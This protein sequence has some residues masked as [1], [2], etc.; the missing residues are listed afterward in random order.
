MSKAK[1]ISRFSGLF[2]AKEKSRFSGLFQGNVAIKEEVREPIEFD[3]PDLSQHFGETSIGE[4]ERQAKLQERPIVEDLIMKSITA[5]VTSFV[6]GI[7]QAVQGATE[8]GKA[9]GKGLVT[10]PSGIQVPSTIPNIKPREPSREIDT[11]DLFV[12]AGKMVAGTIGATFMA[13]PIVAKMTMATPVLGEIGDKVAG[14]T[15]RKIAEL[16]TPYLFSLPLGV[17]SSGAS[18]IVEAIKTTDAFKGL[19]AEAQAVTEEVIHN[20]ALFAI[21]PGLAKI[22][23][24]TT[25]PY[26]RPETR[27]ERL[28][29]EKPPKP[30][31][32]ITTKKPDLKKEF[33]DKVESKEVTKPVEGVTQ[34]KTAVELLAKKEPV[35]AEEF[36]KPIEVPAVKGLTQE[37]FDIKKDFPKATPEELF[38]KGFSIDEVIEKLDIKAA[39]MQSVIV[40]KFNQ[41]Q[42]T[43]EAKPKEVVK[44]PTPE[45]VITDVA[46][47]Q[48]IKNSIAEGEMI[49]K[50]SKSVTGRK[51][52]KDE[53]F[54]VQRSVDNAKKKIGIEPTIEKVKPLEATPKEV[55]TDTKVVP[56]P[57]AIKEAQ[58][59]LGDKFTSEFDKFTET[60]KPVE[61]KDPIF[62]EGRILE[63]FARKTVAAD[64]LGIGIEGDLIGEANK[65][66][67]KETPKDI[68]TKELE[69]ISKI[70]RELK[71]EALRGKF[72]VPERLREHDKDLINYKEALKQKFPNDA[73]ITDAEKGHIYAIEAAK[74]KGL[75]FRQPKHEF[76]QNDPKADEF[77][78][79]NTKGLTKPTT[80]KK[81][82]VKPEAKEGKQYPIAPIG[83]WYGEAN[84]KKAGGE[85]VEMTPD[86]FLA[87]AKPLEIDETARENID[88]LK[89][90]MKSGKTLDPLTLY[91]LDKTNVR[92]SD[93]RHRAIAAKELG[94]EKVPVIDYTKLPTEKPK[95]VEKPEVKAEPKKETE[96][97]I[98]Q[99]LS[100]LG[101]KKAD[102]QTIIDRLQFK[103]I[104]K[105]QKKAQSEVLYEVIKNNMQAESHNLAKSVIEDPRNVNSHQ[106]IAWNVRKVEIENELATLK[107]KDTRK[108][109]WLTDEY[110]DIVEAAFLTS[111]FAGQDFAIRNI[112]VKPDYSL[113]S[114]LARARQSK[115][116]AL[117]EGQSKKI[118]NLTT[119]IKGL[120]KQLDKM[121]D[122]YVEEKRAK[123]KVLAERITKVQSRNAKKSQTK[124][125]KIHET[126]NNIKD[127]LR[128][129]GLRVNDIVGLTTEGYYKLSQLATTYI[130]EA[131]ELGKESANLNQVIKEIQK[132]LPDITADDIYKALNTTRPSIQAKAKTEVEKRISFIK[133]EARLKDR[134]KQAEEGAFKPTITRETTK[135][136]KTLERLYRLLRKSA[137]ETIT[138]GLKLEKA[139]DTIDELQDGLVNQHRRIKQERKV[140]PE[141][142]AELKKKANSLRKQMRLEDTLADLQEQ[143]RKHAE[144]PE[145]NP[146]EVQE[147]I[148]QEVYP[149]DLN[150]LEAKVRITRKSINAYI[151]RLK[152]T[153]KKDV[154]LRVMHGLRTTKASMDV[155]AA[156]RQ[157][158]LSLVESPKDFANNYFK[159]LGSFVS[160]TKYEVIQRD[161]ENHPNQYI[162]EAAGLVINDINELGGTE[163]FM[164]GAADLERIPIYGR[165]IKASNRNMTTMLNLTR[166]TMFD[167]FL[168]AYPN[169]TMK[170]LK[171][172]ASFVNVATGVGS[173]KP[174]IVGNALFFA[175]KFSWSRIEYPYQAFKHWNE[176][177]VRKEILKNLG[178]NALLGS[179]I[180]TLAVL[181]GLE[182]GAD[183]DNPDFGKIKVGNTRVDVFAGTLQP[184]RLS[185]MLADIIT[186]ESKRDPLDL[187]GRFGKYK[188]S[189]TITLSKTLLTG[190]DMVGNKMTKFEAIMSGMIPMGFEDT[191]DAYKEA[192]ITR[193]SWV[194]PLVMSGVS[195]STY[196]G[197]LDDEIRDI[198]YQL[199]KF[200]D[201]K[202][203]EG[204]KKFKRQNKVVRWLEREYNGKTNKQVINDIFNL[205]K[206]YGKLTDKD[207]RLLDKSKKDMEKARMNFRRVRLHP[208]LRRVLERIKSDKSKETKLYK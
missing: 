81:A 187:I 125:E 152:P 24:T 120:Q 50:S 51:M 166:T 153:T 149:K 145:A 179:T 172:W 65:F 164:L 79:I 13:N 175:P 208:R 114:T 104:S 162:R 142:L 54:S 170:E 44:K 40:S 16:A 165:G 10:D 127:D 203:V 185:F 130:Q 59:I 174:G 47:V 95:V 72:K 86:E 184:M 17:A 70:K 128:A 201:D 89:E 42:K 116:S 139:Q 155:S 204:F 37:K 60:N 88:D 41:F 195:I 154:T 6:S 20:L 159:A 49:L 85:L 157:A 111:P 101:L 143:V 23:I 94:I 84:Y 8:V 191:K 32:Q 138:D 134:I 129:L 113:A 183:W 197:G 160:E 69:E 29:P 64:K 136:L 48:E 74:T 33:I 34:E 75:D 76:Y 123:E 25:E 19:D 9:I 133:R 117:L 167:R 12:G 97:P 83:E 207:Q 38:E 45:E 5:P 103:N 100:E 151:E 196:G 105:G 205:D 146:F 180:L 26:F 46:R 7:E 122:N 87:K 124:L 31:E 4:Q 199:K 80:E 82:V 121:Y 56:T 27:S 1:E 178:K 66:G 109:K 58:R 147:K 188:L 186:G 182:V 118:E 55:L 62:E 30:S 161:I 171:S 36:V 119:R 14:D 169:A 96:K 144:D 15:G 67:E 61:G 71:K 11:R 163:E 176:P 98:Q 156:F 112:T 39:R 168:D 43:K 108:V 106:W 57:V 73:I 91:G 92:D 131:V 77:I 150:K 181:A 173:I 2:K 158:Y 177:R 68:L 93:G 3:V 198:N 18:G 63:D 102:A 137:T 53:L 35:K 22:K 99:R 52:S 132:D 194:S 78:E 135:E 148:I 141:E 193:A 140:D 200:K 110:S 192:G 28:L 202:D 190:K 126:R 189:P 21:L 107:D 206:N 115:G 90:H